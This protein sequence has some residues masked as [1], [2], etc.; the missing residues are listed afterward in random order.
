P[1]HHLNAE[2]KDSVRIGMGLVATMSA[3]ILGLLVAST[4]EVYDTERNNVTQMAAKVI[5][6]D[7]A[8]ANYGPAAQP[9]RAVLREAV[10][11]ALTRIWADHEASQSQVE[12]SLAWTEGL[13]TAIQKLAP[14]TEAE[15]ALKAQATQ[16]ASDVGQMR[17]LLF[18]EMETSI[19][20]PLLVVVIVWLTIIYLSI[21][22]FAPANATVIIS[23]LLAALAAAGAIFLILELDQPFSGVMTISAEPLRNA[24]QHLGR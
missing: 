9:A 7:R 10:E 5:H 22:L 21:G 1:G 17:W 19:S 3:L 6:L 2:A 4:K 13:P 15:R 16:F 8:L 23:L 12:P 18:E 14:Q 24:L 11:A 20:V